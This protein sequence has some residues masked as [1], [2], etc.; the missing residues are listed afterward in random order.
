MSEQW[1]VEAGEPASRAA[2]PQAGEGGLNAKR[3]IVIALIGA[4][5]TLV[6]LLLVPGLA[7][8]LG[9]LI[10]NLWVTLLGA[11]AGILGGLLG[12]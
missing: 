12:S 9:R 1:R 10:A 6:A 2:P 8:L 11:V 5:A 4:F 7:T 3:F